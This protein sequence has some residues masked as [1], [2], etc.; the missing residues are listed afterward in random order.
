V[1]DGTG[2]SPLRLLEKSVEAC[3]PPLTPEHGFPS[4]RWHRAQGAPP[5]PAPG[6]P[7][8]PHGL[9]ADTSFLTSKFSMIIKKQRGPGCGSAVQHRW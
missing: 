3:W 5:L 1:T 7:G 9:S 6:F 4:L 8:R 2:R